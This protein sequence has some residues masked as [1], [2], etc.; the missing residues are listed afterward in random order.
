[1]AARSERARIE[2]AFLALEGLLKGIGADGVLNTAELDY[3]SR[4]LSGLGSLLD[5]DPFHEVAQLARQ[6]IEQQKLTED[7]RASL[8]DYCENWSSPPVRVGPRTVLGRI[9]HAMLA[10]IGADKRIVEAELRRLEHWL[11]AAS[12]YCDEEPFHGIEQAVK[13]VL[14][15]GRID[16]DEHAALL[17]MFEQWFDPN[18]AWAEPSKKSHA[19]SSIPLALLTDE[20][21]SVC[22]D[23]QRFV[24]TGEFDSAPRANIEERIREAGGVVSQAIGRG[25]AYL[26]IGN[27]GSE[28]WAY[29]A[30]GRKVEAAL[31][32]QADGCDVQVLSEVQLLD[33]LNEWPRLDSHGLLARLVRRSR[34]SPTRIRRMLN[35][36]DDS[37]HAGH[38]GCY[39]P[40]WSYCVPRAFAEMLDQRCVRAPDTGSDR[41]ETQGCSFGIAPGSI[42]YNSPAA[43]RLAWGA[44][45]SEGVQAL[46]VVAAEEVVPGAFGGHKRKSGRVQFRLLQQRDGRLE[47]REEKTVTQD[48]FIGLLIGPRHA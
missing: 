17:A 29:A 16:A 19:S 15:D 32:L 12:L 43:Y 31:K 25:T 45:L 5:V 42:F 7:Q 14:R 8:L 13:R 2:K 11:Q 38:L 30:Y 46:Q 24:L 40:T 26:A 10:G 21:A 6:A 33:G 3:L 35:R 41:S 34:C 22:V 18:H 28:D 47:A 20:H 1:M 48:E 44:A 36:I 37:M 23:N 4:W 27:R 39:D 9:L